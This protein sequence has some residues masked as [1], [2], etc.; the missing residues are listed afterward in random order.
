MCNAWPDDDG[1]NIVT[2]WVPL[3]SAGTN[4]S[5][6]N[7]TVSLRLVA[8][9]PLTRDWI[10]VDPNFRTTV[11]GSDVQ[12]GTDQAL[13]DQV[14]LGLPFGAFAPAPYFALKFSITVHSPYVG[15]IYVDQVKIQ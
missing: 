7:K 6:A 8:N 1:V 13:F 14:V 4:A 9:P 3:C 5:I 11:A 10:A 15:R 2:L 12:L